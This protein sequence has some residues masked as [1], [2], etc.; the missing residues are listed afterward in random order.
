MKAFTVCLVTKDENGLPQL[1]EEFTGVAISEHLVPTPDES[2]G[3]GVRFQAMVG[4]LWDDHRS[5][6]PSYHSPDELHWLSVPEIEA[7]DYEEE[8]EDE[9]ETPVYYVSDEASP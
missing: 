8:G 5:P 3:T 4:V 2:S 6:S 9:E 7:D 1:N